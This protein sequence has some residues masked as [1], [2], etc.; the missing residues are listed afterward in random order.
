HY[1]NSAA[2]VFSAIFKHQKLGTIVGQE[3]GGRETFTSDPI[4][5]EMPNSALRAVIPVAILALPGKNPDRGVLPDIE[6][7]Y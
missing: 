7:E 3:T 5:I 6:V 2:V 4:I 1:T